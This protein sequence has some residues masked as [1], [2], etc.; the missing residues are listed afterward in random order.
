[1][2]VSHEKCVIGTFLF[3]GHYFGHKPSVFLEIGGF[4]Y[5]SK[6]NTAKNRKEHVLCKDVKTVT[7]SHSVPTLGS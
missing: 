1:M 4:C 6:R 7:T 2:S 5:I 3:S